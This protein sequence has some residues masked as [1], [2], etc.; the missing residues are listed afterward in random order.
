MYRILLNGALVAESNWTPLAQAAW[1]RASRDRD[2]AQHGG[3]A[4]LYKD[5]V[6]I[7]RVQP[8]TLLGHPWPDR[9]ANEIDL[10]D[11]LKALLQLLRDDEWDAK[12]IA[13]AM[14]AYGL[15]TTRSRIDALRGSTAGK[16]TEVTPAELT[17][18]ITA[19][20]ARYKSREALLQPTH[21]R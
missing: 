9:S 1:N 20:L 11:V 17:V 8:E 7:A 6:C 21:A 5:G 13:D 10:R 2:T 19:V 18:L 3:S 15:P 12:E 14:T 16:R 4:E